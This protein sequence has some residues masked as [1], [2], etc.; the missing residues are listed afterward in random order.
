M[1][2]ANKVALITGGTSGIGE[3][4][5][6]LFAKEGAR[7]AITGR[8]EM[9]GRS[10]IEQLV[11]ESGQAIFVRADVRNAD[12]CRRAV[13]PPSAASTFFSTMLASS[14]PTRRSTAP[15]KNGICR[16]TST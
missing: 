16:S 1:R 8:D 6:L 9:R 14:I 13:E 5:A 2:L 7:V 4:T 15:K 11:K 12:E 3:A 10:V